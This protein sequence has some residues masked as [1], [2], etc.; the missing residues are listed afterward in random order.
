MLPGIALLGYGLCLLVK[1]FVSHMIILHF[2]ENRQLQTVSF[3]CHH[4][5]LVEELGKKAFVIP[6]Q[7][8]LPRA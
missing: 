4:V 1:P 3:S 7:N 8:A 2:Y 6:Q 5:R